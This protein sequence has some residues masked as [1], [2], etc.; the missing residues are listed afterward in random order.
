MLA[1][2]RSS[3]SITSVLESLSPL[4]RMH[5]SLV[6]ASASLSVTLCAS[7]GAESATSAEAHGNAPTHLTKRILS[8]ASDALL[9]NSRRNT[10]A[11]GSRGVRRSAQPPLAAPRCRIGCLE[12]Q[13]QAVGPA[14]HLL[15]A[16][17]AVDD[18]VQQTVHLR[19]AEVRGC[20]A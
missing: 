18:E 13:A 6:A 20:S 10:W 7:A 17:Q 3:P 2:H 1:R 4:M 11:R 14:A 15:V 19:D 8:S 16:V 12:P 9:T 5:R